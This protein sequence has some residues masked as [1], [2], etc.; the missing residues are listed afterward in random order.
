MFDYPCPDLTPDDLRQLLRWL[1][2]DYDN[3]D[4]LAV[5]GNVRNAKRWAERYG[6]KVLAELIRQ[7]IIGQQEDPLIQVKCWLHKED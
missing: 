3:K 2:V 7:G 5:A 1:G 6:V 4:I